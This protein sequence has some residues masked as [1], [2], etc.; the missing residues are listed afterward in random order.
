MDTCLLVVSVVPGNRHWGE[1]FGYR[2]SLE[3]EADP[4]E[5]PPNSGEVESETLAAGCA[6]ATGPRRKLPWTGL[7]LVACV[8]GRRRRGLHWR[9]LSG[10]VS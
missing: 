1:E 8:F 6:C 7:F 2:Y 5:D 4:G 3:L 9:C 10:Q